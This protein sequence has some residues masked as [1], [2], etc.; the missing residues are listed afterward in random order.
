MIHNSN[1]RN[2]LWQQTSIAI[3]ESFAVALV[4]VAG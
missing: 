4:Q 2:L 1:S 3:M